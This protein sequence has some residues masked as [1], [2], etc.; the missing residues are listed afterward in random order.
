VARLPKNIIK[1]YG[2]TKKAWRIF[3]GRKRGRKRA[4]PTKIKTR[5]K[6]PVARRYYPRR[7]RRRSSSFNMNRIFKYVR[8][9]SVA[10]PAV[11]AVVERGLTM[12]AA[13]AALHRY[14]GYD[15]DRGVFEPQKLIEGWGPFL[16]T[17]AV[18]YGIQKLSAILRRL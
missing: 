3:K 9:A 8:M 14:S 4:S 15:I 11:A 1:K 18:T 13:K 10:A 2:I 12:E 6:N 16:A 17:T 5:R 7:R